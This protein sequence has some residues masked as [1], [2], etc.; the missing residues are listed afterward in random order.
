MTPHQQQHPPADVHFVSSPLRMG[1][2]H[3]GEAAF[4]GVLRG[5]VSVHPKQCFSGAEL[6]VR[7]AW[8]SLV[9]VCFC[10]HHNGKRCG[11]HGELAGRAAPPSILLGEDTHVGFHSPNVGVCR[12]RAEQKWGVHQDSPMQ[13]GFS[14][15][16]SRLCLGRQHGAAGA[17]CV[18][19]FL[20]CS[21]PWGAHTLAEPR[22]E[23]GVSSVQMVLLFVQCLGRASP[24]LVGSGEELP[25]AE[26]LGRD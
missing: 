19:A 21:W 7:A 1:F 4:W 22:Q 5:G 8:C 20:P 23:G 25:S 9:R 3:R 18:A 26:K 14:E 16:S 17:Q 12:E 10:P 2:A 15:P 6:P 24:S 13:W 11:M